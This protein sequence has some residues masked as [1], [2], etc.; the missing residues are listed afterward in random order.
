M[1]NRGLLQVISNSLFPRNCSA[2][3]L[4]IT[5]GFSAL[6]EVFAANIDIRSPFCFSIAMT[7]EDSFDPDIIH[8]HNPHGFSNRLNLLYMTGFFVPDFFYDVKLFKP[9]STLPSSKSL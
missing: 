6:D 1:S 8:Y 7:T 4:D 5:K 2:Q 3:V 9:L